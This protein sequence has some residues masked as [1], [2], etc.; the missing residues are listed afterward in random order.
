MRETKVTTIGNSLG[1]ILSREML[2]KL[3]VGKGDRLLIVETHNGIELTAYDP[4]VAKQL[5][6]AKTFMREHRDVLRKLAE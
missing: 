3:N 4:E 6:T 1:V 5:E 2:A